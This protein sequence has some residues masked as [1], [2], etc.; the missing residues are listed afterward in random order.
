MFLA[1]LPFSSHL[2]FIFT[3]RAIIHDNLFFENAVVRFESAKIWAEKLVTYSPELQTASR[4]RVLRISNAA[5]WSD[6]QSALG[7][8]SVAKVLETERYFG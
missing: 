7:N 6:L 4:N 1:L 5:S 3:D 2:E 8:V